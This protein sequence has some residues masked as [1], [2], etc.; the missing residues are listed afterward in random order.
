MAIP[1]GRFRKCWNERHVGPRNGVTK[2]LE[3]GRLKKTP[4][5][6]AGL[7]LKPLTI[8]KLSGLFS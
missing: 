8:D 3:S 4:E 5:G 1:A 2:M 6:F 7:L